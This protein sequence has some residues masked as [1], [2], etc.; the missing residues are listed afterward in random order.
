MDAMKESPGIIAGPHAPLFWVRT[1][2][3]IHLTKPRIISLVLFTTF[4]GF[5]TGIDGPVSLR[6]LFHTLAG[7]ALV[8][9]G[10]GA[11]NMYI[12]RRL[13]VL[14][15]R[16]ARRPLAAGR[17]QPGAALIFAMAISMGGFLYLYVL[18]NHLAGML[19][20]IIFAGYLIL[21]TPL[22]RKTWLSTFLGAIIG[23]L[24]AVLGWTAANNRV[25]C[26]PWILFAIVFLWQM[27]HFY[28]IGWMNR[29][30]YRR[31]GFSLLPAI[32]RDGR[33]ISRQ[34]LLFIALLVTAT[35][36]PYLTGNAG[37]LYL[38]GA[39]AAGFAFLAFG[40]HF[41]RSRTQYSARN[42]FTASALYLPLLL[43]LLILDKV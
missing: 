7:T 18:V 36:L 3:F 39:A 19:S 37:E 6:M 33:R 41:A 4:V 14:M 15:E 17:L 23:A 34:A 42:L 29:E 8:A 32:D 10:A 13:D 11:F 28:A 38:A 16:T 12:E 26:E 1:S 30:D 43:T 35:S 9:G 40:W 24:P 31:A 5:Y 20:A 27:P 22:K 25:S 2:D 21:Y